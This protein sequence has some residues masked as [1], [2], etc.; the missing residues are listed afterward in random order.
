MNDFFANCCFCS[1]FRSHY[2]FKFGFEFFYPRIQKYDYENVQIFIQKAIYNSRR[3]LTQVEYLKYLRFSSSR[4]FSRVLQ[5]SSELYNFS[6]VC[7]ISSF[8]STSRDWPVINRQCH[9]MKL[10][11]LNHIQHLYKCVLIR[12]Q[13]WTSSYDTTY[14]GISF[15]N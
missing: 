15:Q 6:D 9:K 10:A 14:I 8:K 12:Y 13:W 1:L 5:R 3:R 4:S 2:H 7:P 11:T